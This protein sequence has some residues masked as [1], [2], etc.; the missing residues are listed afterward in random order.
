VDGA[1]K[2]RFTESKRWTTADGI[3]MIM[4]QRSCIHPKTP[5]ALMSRVVTAALA[6]AAFLVLPAFVRE[7]AARPPMPAELPTSAA[8]DSF[9]VVFETTKGTFVARAHRAWSP[10]AV[11][12]LYHLV[13]AGFYDGTVIFR[14]GPTVNYKGGLVVQFGITNDGAVNAAWDTTGIPDE[15]VIQGHRRGRIYFARGGPNTRST[16]LAIDLTANTPLDTVSSEGVVGFPAIGEV[17]AGIDLLGGLQRKH[18]NTI[19][20][21]WDSVTAQGRAFLDRKYPGLDRIERATIGVATEA[22]IIA[23]GGEVR[24]ATDRPGAPIVYANLY[25]TAIT[26]ADLVGIS[27][28]AELESLDVYRTEITD[29]GVA[30]IAGCARVSYLNLFRTRVGDAGVARLSRLRELETLIL[31]GTAV[32]DRGLAALEPLKALR[33]VSV[34]ET[35]VGDAGL[36]HL[37]DLPKLEVVLT[38]S[39]KVTEAGQARLSKARPG[40]QFTVP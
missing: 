20:E 24:R 7:S 13:N 3:A 5:E 4:L 12:R 19:F 26:D 10:H 16:Q 33:K 9:H 31:G 2:V 28:H 23:L 17:S 27:S 21:H 15:P 11:D 38:G 36:E 1:V 30:H 18:G 14:V 32:T 35:A 22:G 29:A 37:V 8:P 6:V 39:S 25:S 34:A 40:V